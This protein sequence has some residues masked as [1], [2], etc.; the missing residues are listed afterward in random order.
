MSRETVV[1][2]R[3]VL[4]AKW[5][6][7]SDAELQDWRSGDYSLVTPSCRVSGW[8]MAVH[9]VRQADCASTLNLCGRIATTEMAVCCH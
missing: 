2:M 4:H 7:F 3:P 6:R 5:V 8:V 9:E 1:V